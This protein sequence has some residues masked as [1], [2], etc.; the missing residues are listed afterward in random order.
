MEG[1]RDRQICTTTDKTGH[2]DVW[3]TERF[4]RAAGKQGPG[5]LQKHCSIN[6]KTTAPAQL[7]T[8]TSTQATWASVNNVET[9]IF[10]NYAGFPN[11]GLQEKRSHRH[12]HWQ[13]CGHPKA[14]A[15]AGAHTRA[16]A[17]GR[18]TCET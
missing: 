16:Q 6:V 10:Q 2:V 18:H 4:L 17:H 3:H 13:M 5:L 12:R 15:H 8:T 14:P 9:A 7:A 11:C 1:G